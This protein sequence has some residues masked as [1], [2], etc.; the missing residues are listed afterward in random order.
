MRV[1]EAEPMMSLESELGVVEAY[2]EI[3]KIR[4]G[5]RLGYSIDAP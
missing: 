3:E 1:V 5:D 4:L 2:L